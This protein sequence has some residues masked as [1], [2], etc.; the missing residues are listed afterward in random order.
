[1]VW[2]IS[3]QSILMLMQ[4]VSILTFGSLRQ[5]AAHLLQAAIQSAKTSSSLLFS[6]VILLLFYIALALQLIGPEKQCQK[7]KASSAAR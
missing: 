5:E 2:Q 6:Y 7:L 1:V 3:A 4:W